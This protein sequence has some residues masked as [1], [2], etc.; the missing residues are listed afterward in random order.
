V[1]GGGARKGVR[2]V[3]GVDKDGEGRGG[4]EE[5]GVSIRWGGVSP[6]PI[7]TRKCPLFGGFRRKGEDTSV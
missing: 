1:G 2:G 4:G 3:R 5:R 6:P 7:R